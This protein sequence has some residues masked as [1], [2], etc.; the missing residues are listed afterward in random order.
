MPLLRFA[1][2]ISLITAAL[3]AQSEFKSWPL[4]QA[5]AELRPTISRA[6]LVI[7]EMQGAVLQELTDALERRGTVAAM[8][9]CHLDANVIIQRVARNQGIA[10]GRTSNRLRNPAN[11]PRRWAAPF[12]TA[13]AGQRANDVNGFAV[14][15]GG[16]IGVLRPIV[17]Q[18]MCTGCHGPAE[19]FAPGLGVV[20]SRRYPADRAVGFKDGEIRGWFWVELP[21]R[22]PSTSIVAGVLPAA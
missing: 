10:A 20:L 5:P 14:D 8:S 13:H 11:A 9:F 4:T 3:A 2:A 22:T 21:K 7:A 15:L 18:P 12:V 19:R 16:R 1:I 17:E 6:D